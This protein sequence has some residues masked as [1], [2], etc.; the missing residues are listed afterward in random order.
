MTRSL[1]PLL[2]PKGIAARI[3][4]GTATI[5]AWHNNKI[6]TTTKPSMYLHCTSVDE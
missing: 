3:H 4:L 6:P 5:E 2:T 1:V